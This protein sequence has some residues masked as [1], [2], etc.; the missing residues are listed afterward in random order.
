M[1]IVWVSCSVK[2]MRA[3]V[4]YFVHTNAQHLISVYNIIVAAF[5]QFSV[6]LYGLSLRVMFTRFQTSLVKETPF[7]RALIN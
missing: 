1:D 5:E 3:T 2:I 6:E 7:L 4:S